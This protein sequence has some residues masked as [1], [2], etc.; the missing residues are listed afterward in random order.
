MTR[1]VRLPLLLAAL[2]LAAPALA[3]THSHG[4]DPAAERTP[5]PEGAMVYIISPAD[6]AT[7]TSPVRVVFGLRGMGVAPAG[8]DAPDTGHHHLMINV[9]L[10]ELDLTQGFPTDERHR[11]F[12]RG[13]TEAAI[14]LPPGTHTL[15]LVLGDHF[16]IPHDPPVI[17][18][19]IT[20]TVN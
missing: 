16:H 3:Q 10:E 19:E 18:E 15:R 8:V 11:H 6:G 20:I 17:S 7:V 5:S 9:P 12:G 14:E 2:T 13:Q 4:A 1:H